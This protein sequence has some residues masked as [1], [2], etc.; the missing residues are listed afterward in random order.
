MIAQNFGD[1]TPLPPSGTPIIEAVRLFKKYTGANRPAVNEVSFAIA[2][3]EVFGFL[4]ENG[5]GKTTTIKMLTGLIPPSAGVARIA[6]FDI[7]AEPLRAKQHIGYI[8]DNPY[9]YDKL[10]GWEFME[11]LGDFYHVLDTA[12]RRERIGELL[13]LFDLSEKADA[14][15]GGYSRGM[16]QKI[17][18]A[19]ALLH[20]P[21]ALFLD[22]PTVGLDP[23][24]IH[25]LR[26]ILRL[27]ARRGAAVFLSTHVLEVAAALCDR[28]GVLHQGEL[29]A[30]GTPQELTA[31]GTYSLEQRFLEL[32][33]GGW[34][35]DEALRILGVPPDSAEEGSRHD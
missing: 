9:L 16:R 19:A 2:S 27:V 4:G 11:V 15:I 35:P 14:L 21:S 34:S 28:I 26:D 33:G 24:S 22:E 17:A 3:G 8:P 23:K 7:Q 6:G 1:V 12:A 18:L 13:H 31:G 32:T 25:R 30:L 10:T 5:A 29:V 20:H